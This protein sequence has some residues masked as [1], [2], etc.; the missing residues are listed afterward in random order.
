M[1]KWVVTIELL[2]GDNEDVAVRAEADSMAEAVNQGWAWA[3][4]Q[5]LPVTGAWASPLTEVEDSWG[6][7]ADLPLVVNGLDDVDA[8]LAQMVLSGEETRPW[9]GVEAVAVRAILALS[10]QEDNNLKAQARELMSDLLRER[11]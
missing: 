5:K 10:R 3:E 2:N 9:N 4:R 1:A 11:G 6:S 7:Q 8:V